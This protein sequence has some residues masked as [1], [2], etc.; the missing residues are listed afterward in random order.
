[1]KNTPLNWKKA[2]TFSR[3]EKRG[4]LILTMLLILS[5]TG[6]IIYFRFIPPTKFI[7][8]IPTGWSL[9]DSLDIEMQF[10]S[11][12]ATSKYYSRNFAYGGRSARKS[13]GIDSV[14]VHSYNAPF[15]RSRMVELN[16]ADTIELKGLP[17]IGPWLARKIVEY[18]EKLGGFYSKEQLLEVYRLTPGK[19]DTIAPFL[20]IDTSLVKRIPV[21]LV[22]LDE[23]LN[24]PYMSRSQ[25]KGLLAYREK[26]G[27]FGRIEDIRKCL[28]IDEK[29][30]EKVRDYL[31][32][33]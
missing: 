20:L 31:K 27:P 28:L 11:N 18:R 30:F 9:A 10:D 6:R 26:H 32:V 29:T 4:L 3:S 23:L 5:V 24:H 15:K 2:F 1:M 7:F 13:Y 33:R 12:Y 19:L 22:N 21:N 14:P 8:Q 17:S 16:T 25:A